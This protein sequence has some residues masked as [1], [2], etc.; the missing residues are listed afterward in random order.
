MN[1]RYLVRWQTFFAVVGILVVGGLLAQL[2]LTRQAVVVPVR[3]GIYVEG[4]VGTPQYL[5]PLLATTDLDRVVSTL[6]FDGL[7]TLQSD[8]SVVPA[9][10]EEWE[11]AASGTVYTCT[12]RSGARWHDGTPVTS[13]DVLFTLELVRSPDIP[14]PNQLKELWSRVQVEALGERRVRFVLERPY[15]PFLSYTTL[16]ILPAHLL[17]GISS[18]DLQFSPL[19]LAPVGTGPF[20]FV[21]I[22][23]SEDGT[24]SMDLEANPYY[25][26]QPFYLEGVRLLF[27][28]DRG[29]LEE[30]LLRGDVD[31]AFGLSS[32]ALDR[33]AA[34]PDFV[35]YRT[36]LQACTILFLN[37]QSP[38]LSDLRLRQAIAMAL[39]RSALLKGYEDRVF[40]ANG[41]ISPISWAYKPDLAPLPY[42]PASAAELLEEA[43]WQDHNGD[44]IRDRDVRS[45]ELTLLTQDIPP[46]RVTLARRIEQ[47]LAPLG[48][49]VRVVVLDDPQAF[50]TRFAERSF[51]LLLYGWGQ[52][53]RDPDEFALWHSSQA[54]AEGLNLSSLQDPEIDAL[55]EK[56]RTVRERDVRTQLYWQF[57]ERFVQLVPAIPLYYPVYTYVVNS[58]IRG[59]QLGPLNDF[60]DRFQGVTGWYIK[61]EKVI[62]DRSRPASRSGDSR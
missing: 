31:G 54:G 5:N 56:G 26:R 30:A 46:E 14:D 3:G 7:S 52:L 2:S 9:L 42:D 13:A 17:E 8:G 22:R 4:M 60:G 34:D 6:L 29:A 50:R 16:P 32:E 37:T 62:L 21:Q 53:G 20:R 27:Y 58:R 35:S 40:A 19:N 48:I 38:L 55:L 51:D 15:A 12:L 57:Q 25:Y 61:T 24:L 45:L 47:Q 28:R 59:I 44:G 36:Y 11:I 23:E 10:A 39:D 1:T 41:P 49:A 43:G 33:V 18:Q